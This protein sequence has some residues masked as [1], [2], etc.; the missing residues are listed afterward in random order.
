MLNEVL[1]KEDKKSNLYNGQGIFN[2]QFQNQIIDKYECDDSFD[3]NED[4]NERL[5]VYDGTRRGEKQ[6]K[7]QQYNRLIKLKAKGATKFNVERVILGQSGHKNYIR[8]N[9]D[10]C[11]K[12]SYT[13]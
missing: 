11:S 1:S 5:G 2:G 6:F 8:N 10:T 9:Y 13:I 12:T 7:Y 4:I 3:S